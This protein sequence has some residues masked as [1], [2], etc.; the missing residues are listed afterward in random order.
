[1]I[2]VW[3]TPTCGCCSAWAEH[4]SNAGFDVAATNVDQR[5]L[6]QI[7][8]R[9]LVPQRLRS[10]HTATIG[11]YVIEGHVPAKDI[12]LLA[13]LKP[14]ISGIAVPG[15]PIGSPGMEMGGQ[16]EP[17]ATYAFDKTGPTAIFARHG[18]T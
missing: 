18:G 9:L 6:E 3:K 7:K 10:C 16:T 2:Q 11:G 17:Y 13:T 4:L 5:E 8:D 14:E 1:M 12:E 15:M